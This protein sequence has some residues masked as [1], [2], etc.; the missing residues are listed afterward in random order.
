MKN[1]TRPFAIL[2]LVIISCNGSS[3]PEPGDILQ[4]GTASWYGPGFHGQTTSSR[5]RYNQEKLTAA[6]RTLPFNTTVKVINLENQKSVDVRINDR[7]PYESGRII[8]LSKAAAKK[9][10]MLQSGLAEVKLILI[11]ADEPIPLDLEQ[12][13]YTLQLGEYNRLPPAKRYASSIGE[14]ARIEQR[15]PYAD[16]H[17][18]VYMIY[19]GNYKSLSAANSDLEQLRAKGHDGIVKQIN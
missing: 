4:T 2:L 10:D 16:K 14:E 19:F 1:S 6:H 11:N 13:V 9:I 17:V 8:D 15:F 12:P 18:V 7:G 3:S 5:E